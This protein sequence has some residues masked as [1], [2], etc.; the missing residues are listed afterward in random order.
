MIDKIHRNADVSIAVTGNDKDNL[1]ASLIAQRS[2]VPHTISLVN[3]RA[4]DN[5][6]DDHGENIIVE[7]SLIT[8]S[9]ML[10]ELRK[11]KINNAHCLRRGLGEVW[12]V[13]IDADSLNIS[14]TVDEIGLP[15]KCKIGAIYRQNEI[16]YPSTNDKIQEGDI[17]IV[18]VSPQA[19]RKTEQIFRI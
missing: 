6:I 5:L 12:E 7:R 17:L 4:F 3:S 8:T 14:K 18:F 15:D 1:L 2:N 16:I 13:R 10:Q 11:A 19:I 9:A